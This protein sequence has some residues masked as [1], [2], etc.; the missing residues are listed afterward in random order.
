MSDKLQLVASVASWFVCITLT[1]ATTISAQAQGRP[2]SEPPAAGVPG[3]AAPTG[4]SIAGG[5]M[6]QDPT[7]DKKTNA[8]PAEIITIPPEPFDGAPITIMSG[9]CVTL[10]TE[11]GT[12]EIEMI[13]EV[14]P[15]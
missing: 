4:W 8:R 15:E 9:Q 7:P 12:I 1:A 3:G 14:A 11:A 6:L 13:P 5:P 10:D 2:M